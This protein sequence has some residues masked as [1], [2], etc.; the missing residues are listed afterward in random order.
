MGDFRASVKIEWEC[1]GIEKKCEMWINYSRDTHIDPRVDDFFLDAWN[2]SRHELEEIYIKADHEQM[3]A[4]E[5][6]DY[7]RLKLKFET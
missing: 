5:R 3:E 1:L 7:D 4:Q 2:D 6:R